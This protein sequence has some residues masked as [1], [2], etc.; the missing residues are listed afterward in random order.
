MCIE[1]VLSNEPEKST[2]VPRNMKGRK[3]K[4]GFAYLTVVCKISLDRFS[5]SP[6]LFC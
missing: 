2:Q 3:G 6:Q 4:S 1:S 5:F